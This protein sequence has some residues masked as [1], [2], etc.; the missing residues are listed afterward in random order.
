M[1]D[2]SKISLG[3]D[4]CCFI[5]IFIS[6][7]LYWLSPGMRQS[8]TLVAFT[9]FCKV[10]VSIP[11]DLE[12]NSKRRPPKHLNNAARVLL[13]L[14]E[15]VSVSWLLPTFSSFHFKCLQY[16]TVCIGTC[17]LCQTKEQNMNVLLHV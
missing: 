4:E 8:V 6:F 9:V 3:E 2:V 1:S 12:M 10:F 17:Y 15:C 11:V 16:D 13:V 5:L 14:G 7:C